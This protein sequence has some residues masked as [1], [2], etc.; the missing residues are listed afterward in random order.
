MCLSIRYL[1]FLNCLSCLFYF[2]FFFFK[3]KTAYEM[4]IS[5]G[6]QTCAL[7][8]CKSF[9]ERFPGVDIVVVK[10]TRFPGLFEVQIGMDLLYT[11]GNVDY[12]MQG[13]LIDA[14]SRTDLTAE[15]LDALSKVAFSSLPLDLAIKQVDEKRVVEGKG[16][17]GSVAL[18][19]GRL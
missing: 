13:S 19:G 7:P 8:I 17:A 6:V 1:M 2:F 18:S 15:R 14:K 10:R 16:V 12:L 4:R 11:D 5:D 3:Q 9:Q